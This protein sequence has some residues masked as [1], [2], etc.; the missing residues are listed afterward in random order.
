M[1]LLFNESNLGCTYDILLNISRRDLCV[2]QGTID[3]YRREQSSDC[4]QVKIESNAA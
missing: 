1:N 2:R 3:F 4:D